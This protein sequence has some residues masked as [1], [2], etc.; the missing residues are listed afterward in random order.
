M[1]LVRVRQ[2]DDPALS[3]VIP[4]TPESD[5]RP[6]LDCLERQ[7]LDEPYE[8]VLVN[9]GTVDRSSAR[10]QGLTAARADVVALTDDD[11]RPPQQWLAVAH[12][13]F[14]SD[15]DLVCL[16]GPV[17]GG[18]RSFGP[19]HY[20]GCNLAVHR[21]TAIAVGGFRTAFSE[22]REDVE[23][24]WRMEKEAEGECRY[25]ADFRMCHPR[26]PRTSMKLDLE[27]RLRAEYP[28]RYEE[29]M[30]A[31]ITRRLYRRARAAGITQP[32]QR[33]RNAVRRRFSSSDNQIPFAD[34]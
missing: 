16:E 11:T 12:R 28:E 34:Q 24:G 19:R 4:S 7:T 29:V 5:H 3:V 15:P 23:F 30:N 13:E 22:W 6:T 26:V 9:D 21:P 27:R 31:T 2:A 33:V 17:Y 14:D 18:C 20:V 10:N 1:G 8:V 32:L 25:E